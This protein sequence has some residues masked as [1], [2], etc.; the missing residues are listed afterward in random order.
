MALA[1]GLSDHTVHLPLDKHKALYLS[2]LTLLFFVI[3]QLLKL[4]DLRQ[5]CKM[6][7]LHSGDLITGS[8]EV[9]SLTVLERKC[10]L[11]LLP[12]LH[13]GS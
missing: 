7:F 3:V 6:P 11:F 5:I 9:S 4:K 1:Y 10:D 2:K 8:A 13:G 12:G